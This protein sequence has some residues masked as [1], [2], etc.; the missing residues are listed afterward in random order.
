MYKFAGLQSQE[1][2]PFYETRA[3]NN[4][5]MGNGGRSRLYV[6]NSDHS[7]NQLQRFNALKEN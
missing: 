7:V 1:A 3:S 5:L 2:Q 4:V 6:Y